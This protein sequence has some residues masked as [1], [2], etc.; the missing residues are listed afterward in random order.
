MRFLNLSKFRNAASLS[1]GKHASVFSGEGIEFGG[2]RS[3]SETD[4]AR[5][6][7]WKAS[8]RSGK[9]LVKTFVPDREISVWCAIDVSAYMGFGS[10]GA[11]RFDQAVSVFEL[12]SASAI[13]SGN[14]AGAVAYA[15]ERV[16]VLR[17]TLSH[18]EIRRFVSSL[19]A[20]F[21]NLPP[22]TSDTLPLAVLSEKIRNKS[23]VFLISDLHPEL[24]VGIRKVLKGSHLFSI[25]VSHP[26]DTEPPRSGIAA[27]S[28]GF[29]SK[30]FRF[31]TSSTVSKGRDFLPPSLKIARV[32][33]VE[34]GV[35]QDPFPALN[36]LLSNPDA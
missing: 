10:A 15:G 3:Y 19:R 26:F 4:D 2:L 25:R 34:V 22:E 36:R 9:T 30:M 29:F 27:V 12:I 8:L 32:P 18:A 31:K 35:G 5:A 11:T 7:D 6:I 14:R 28:G 1:S 21:A 13:G 33:S 23:V 20:D 17:P 24:P 16:R